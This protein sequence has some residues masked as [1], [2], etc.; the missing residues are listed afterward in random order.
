MKKAQTQRITSSSSAQDTTTSNDNKDGSSTTKKTASPSA[1]AAWMHH[2]PDRPIFH[3]P[4]SSTIEVSSSYISNDTIDISPNYIDFGSISKP[5]N[6]STT[7]KMT[8]VQPIQ[9]KR[10]NMTN[11]MDIP[12]RIVRFTVMVE[13]S[14]ELESSSRKRSRGYSVRDTQH[15]WIYGTVQMDNHTKYVLHPTHKSSMLNTSLTIYMNMEERI[16]NGVVIQPGETLVEAITL[17]PLAPEKLMR[18][19][20]LGR[21]GPRLYRGTILIWFAP[22]SMDLRDFKLCTTL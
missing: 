1:V 4:L 10:L 17:F 13:Q 9:E 19:H 6:V 14:P 8:T 21:D 15:D 18:V 7:T 2:Y 3:E 20:G 22:V 12:L 16:R 11:R 5:S